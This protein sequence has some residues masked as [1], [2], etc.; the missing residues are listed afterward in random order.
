MNHAETYPIGNYQRSQKAKRKATVPTARQV[1]RLDA[2]DKRCA[3]DT[4]GQTKIRAAFPTADGF[5][6]TTFLPKWKEQQTAEALERPATVERDFYKSLSR[7]AKHYDVQPMP[8]RKF[9]HPYNIALALWDMETKLGRTVKNWGSI[10]VVQENDRT[11]IVSQERYD[12][13][14]KLYYI[15]IAP[16]YRMLK[17]PGRKHTARLLLSVCS[18]LYHIA[19]IPYYRQEGSYL[20]RTYEMLWEWVM[21]DEDTEETK[22]YKSELHQAEWIGDH[23]EQK[24]FNRTNLTV[25]KDRMDSFK[26]RD[27]FDHECRMLAHKTFDLYSR[28]PNESVFGNDKRYDENSEDDYDNEI[29]YME[30]YISFFADSEGWL[31]ESLSEC[32]NNEFNECGEVEEPTLTKRFDGS[33]VTGND[34]DFENR[35]FTVLEEICYLLCN[36]KTER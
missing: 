35:L 25:F 23:V 9:N 24:I 31:C 21:Q 27:E 10:R 15:P 29:V 8:T 36:Y 32:V 4:K 17:D 28:Y 20:Y 11:F 7:L 33:K 26:I 1:C 30:K 16:L 2:T 14:A 34:L 19:D 22:R 12:T 5:L 6:K 18:Y 3:G 13:G